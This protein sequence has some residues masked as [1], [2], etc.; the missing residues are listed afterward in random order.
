M[1]NILVNIHYTGRI[2]LINKN[3]PLYG[4]YLSEGVYGILRR[5]N[6]L[7]M[8]RTTPEKAKA[9]IDRQRVEANREKLIVHDEIQIKVVEP[10]HEEEY[11]D[12]IAEAVIIDEEE[13]DEKP[14]VFKDNDITNDDIFRFE[15]SI[16]KDELDDEI[17]ELLE[18][19]TIPNGFNI[20]FKLDPDFVKSDTEFHFYTEE[21]LQNMTKRQMKEVLK[22]RGYE[23]G[24]YAGKYHDTV[25]MLIQ[26]VLK[27]QNV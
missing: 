21:E 27:T 5:Y 25:E 14:I 3:G 8:E 10:V 12:V 1:A 6:F 24:P 23:K 15:Q 11:T 20:D 2:P 7:Q 9:L 22:S 19:K 4:E 26:K 18:G 17:D 16:I 13:I